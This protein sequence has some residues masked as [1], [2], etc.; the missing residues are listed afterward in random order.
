MRVVVTRPQDAAAR[1]VQAL[2]RQGVDAVGLPLIEIL[3]AADI[4][5]VQAAWRSVDGLAAAM[6]VSAA[7]VEHF[8]VDLPGGTCV[9]PSGRLPRAWA[10]GPG[11][12]AA[13]RRHGVP[14]DRI[15]APAEDSGQFDSEALW[16]LVGPSVRP[17]QRVLLVRGTQPDPSEASGQPA[18]DRGQ[19]RD[20]LA[21][22]LRDQGALVEYVVAYRRVA[23]APARLRQAVADLGLAAPACWLFTSSQAIAHLVQA[24]PGHDWSACRAL[25]T[26]PRIAAAARSAGFGVVRESRPAL[27][28]V[29]A[30]IKSAP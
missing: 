28:D 24:L 16:R 9:W 23:P 14:A 17:G 18:S 5:A 19:G 21:R 15:D 4:G 10:P 22:Q 20:W 12:A 7:A 2:A 11:T 29:V 26:H 8:F 30:S 6:F 3:P 13:L 27:S 1:W 25:V